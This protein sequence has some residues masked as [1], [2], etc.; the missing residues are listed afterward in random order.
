[1]ESISLP[2][3]QKSVIIAN[4]HLTVY[5][6]ETR[7][8]QLKNINTYFKN[9][10]TVKDRTV[11]FGGDFNAILEQSLSDLQKEWK[12]IGYTKQSNRLWQDFKIS[13]DY[14]FKKRNETFKNAKLEER[15][16]I[17][18]KNKTLI[19]IKNLQVTTKKESLNILKN[20]INNWYDDNNIISNKN[21]NSKFDK[22]IIEKYLEIGIDY[23]T[24]DIDIY[25][26]KI[27]S[28]KNKDKLISE[29]KNLL[30]SS[31]NVLE[32]KLL[33]YQNNIDFLSNNTQTKSIY[34]EVEDKINTVK[35]DV[36]HV[37]YKQK[38]LSNIK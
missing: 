25:K 31:L 4:T 12:S 10:T 21:L 18:E 27:K 34:K 19:K 8:E 28:I 2:E 30:D 14:F 7:L 15:K 38:I 20:Y 5:A 29:E 35:K 36:D 17:D 11:I 16:I 3:Q 13:T 9:Q 26:T 1:M 37:N 6:E 33:Q 32:K 22:I 23:R 24:A